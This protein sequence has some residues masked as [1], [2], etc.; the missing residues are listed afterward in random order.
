MS[1]VKTARKKVDKAEPLKF[2]DYEMSP[3]EEELAGQWRRRYKERAPAPQLKID[4]PDDG[5]VALEPDHESQTLWYIEYWNA[6]GTTNRAFADMLLNQLL[7]VDFKP[8]GQSLS[9]KFVNGS[10][11]CG[12][13]SGICYL[14]DRAWLHRFCTIFGAI[15]CLRPVISAV[16][17]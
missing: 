3:A 8:D 7:E 4:R 13:A 11:L 1:K 16:Y 10:W 9:P 15:G 17:L 5:P 12:N 2:G 14:Q 6:F